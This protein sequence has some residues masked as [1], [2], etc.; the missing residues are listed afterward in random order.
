MNAYDINDF[1]QH[2]LSTWTEADTDQRRDIIEKVWAPEGKLIIS[3]HGITLHGTAEIAAH[4]ALIHDDM[5]VTKRLVFSYDQQINADDALLLRW[6]MTAPSG[7][8]VGRGV[9]IV[10]RNADGQVTTA[11]MFMGVS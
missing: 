5:I 6:S 7:D 4:I 9:D 11:Y 10:F 2:Y 3:S 8:V 1:Q